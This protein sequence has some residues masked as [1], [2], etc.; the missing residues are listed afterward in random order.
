MA[1]LTVPVNLRWGDMDVFE[2]INNVAYVGYL[3]DARVSLLANAGFAPELDGIRQFVVRHEIE[4]LKPLTF[5]AEP[6][7][8]QV[9]I[10]SMGNS[11]YVIGYCLLDEEAE[12][13][14][15]K[16]TMVCMN[17]ESGLPGRIPS[18]LKQTYEKLMR[19]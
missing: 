5:R 15:A 19:A 1:I 7:Q 16:T 8:M 13:M 2:H 12:Y 14:R 6:M 17:M 4:Y 9:W 18:Q 3:E 11:S 10:E